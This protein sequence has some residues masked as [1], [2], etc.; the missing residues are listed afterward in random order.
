MKAKKAQPT[1]QRQRLLGVIVDLSG[2]EIK[3]LPEPGRVAKIKRQLAEA[4]RNNTLR[5]HDAAKLAGRVNFLATSTFGKVGR[6][7]TKQSAGGPPPDQAV[8]PD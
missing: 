3:V 6:A 1:A 7:A 4:I 2:A 8:R 5:P